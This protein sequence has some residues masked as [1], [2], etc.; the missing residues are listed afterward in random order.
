MAYKIT[1]DRLDCAK[2]K[3]ESITEKELL[4]MGA[5]IEALIEGGHIETDAV[6]VKPTVEQ[7]ATANG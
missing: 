7:G 5:N 2:S 3:G 4:A 6:Q 1:S